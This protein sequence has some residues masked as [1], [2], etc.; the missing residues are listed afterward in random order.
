[1]D[2]D[3]NV[4]LVQTDIVWEDKEANLQ[5]L[6][7]LLHSNKESTDLIILPEMFATG[8]SMQPEHLAERMDGKCVNWMAEQAKDMGAVVC[9]SLIVE[10]GGKFF[11]RLV[12]MRPDGSYEIYDK[13]HL[14]RMSAEQEHYSS[15]DSRLIVELKGW[16]IMPLVCYDLRFPVWSRNQGDYDLLVYVANWPASRSFVWNHL[17][18]A[19]ALENQAYVIG[20]NRIGEDKSG[21]GYRG[22]SLA[23]APKGNC[24]TTILPNLSKME[25]VS[26]SKEDLEKFRSSFPVWKDRDAFEILP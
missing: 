3:L 25:T 21:T 11:N 2:I 8:F 20:V 16:R 10:D 14:F 15:G 12:W 13:R 9:G 22:D 26:L 6:A 24:L 1:M 23:I 18:I 17:L 5:H 19:R 4:S 7:S